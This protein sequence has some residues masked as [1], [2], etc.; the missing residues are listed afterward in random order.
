MWRQCTDAFSFV[1]RL[2][3]ARCDLPPIATS[4]RL[5][6]YHI[7]FLCTAHRHRTSFANGD[8]RVETVLFV[9]VAVSGAPMRVVIAKMAFA[10]D[11]M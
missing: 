4:H 3:V 5:A 7:P 2:N 1:S 9:L 11:L 6:L 8:F 10:V